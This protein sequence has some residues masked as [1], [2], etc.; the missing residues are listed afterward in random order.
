MGTHPEASR[1]PCS[2]SVTLRNLPEL[3]TAEAFC[4]LLCLDLWLDPAVAPTAPTAGGSL[5]SGEWVLRLLPSG[6]DP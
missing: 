5:K 2:I 6:S 4:R 1:V 3:T